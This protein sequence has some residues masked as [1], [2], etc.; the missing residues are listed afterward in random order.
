MCVHG[1]PHDRLYLCYCFVIVNLI[2]AVIC[3][4]ISALHDDEKAKLH[5]SFDDA[6]VSTDG[7]SAHPVLQE[8]LQQQLN[9]LESHVEELTRMQEETMLTLQMLTANLAEKR[10][11]RKLRRQGAKRSSSPSSSQ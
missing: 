1:L 2:I 11:Q 3:D 8:D 7:E 5:G 4:A 6:D 9:T 10:A